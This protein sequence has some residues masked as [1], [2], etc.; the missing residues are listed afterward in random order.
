VGDAT[1]RELP[2]RLVVSAVEINSGQQ[3]Y[4]GLPGLDDV[5]V[6][7]AIMASCAMPG[8][9]PPREIRGGWW[10]DGGIGD[11]LPVRA[12]AAGMDCLVAVDVGA[13][14]AIRADVQEAGFAS[15]F[16]RAG[17]IVF[18]RSTESYLAGWRAPSILLVR[19]RVEEIPS[20]SFRH[21]PVLIAAGY[22]ATLD[23]LDAAG[24]AVRR[25]VPGIHP[26]RWVRVEVRR[27]RCVGC[28]VC[29]ALAPDGMLQMDAARRAVADAR[30]VQWSP[31][32]GGFVRH[33]PTLAISATPAGPPEAGA[34]TSGASTGTAPASS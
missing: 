11:N 10:V 21:T 12:V 2:R 20:F 31:L 4:W 1:F 15:V 30:S 18:Q 19:P 13:R 27:E 5:R 32:D 16:A 14:D 17:E 3:V 7:D 6:V 33:C 29:V 28:G 25:G 34:S 9:F 22:R 8:F 23:A 26:R 24:D